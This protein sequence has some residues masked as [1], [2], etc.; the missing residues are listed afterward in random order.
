[1]SFWQILIS[2]VI[3]FGISIGLCIERDKAIE[4][5]VNEILENKKNNIEPYKQD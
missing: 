4:R 5:K 2:I 1:M 3:G